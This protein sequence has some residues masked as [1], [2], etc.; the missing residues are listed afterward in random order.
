ARVVVSDLPL[1]GALLAREAG[2]VLLDPSAEAAEGDLPGGEPEPGDGG[3]PGD[4]AYL[5]YT[6]G[7]TGTPKAVMVE[8]AQLTHT[9]RASLETLG[10]APGDVVAALASTSFDI[11]LLELVTPLL[12]GGAVRIVPHEVARDPEEL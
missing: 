3:G 8:H 11:S 6:S 10:F 5:I 9:L 7:S 12:A 2:V 4:L 1:A